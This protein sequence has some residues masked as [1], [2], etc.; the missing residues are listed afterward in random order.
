M[1]LYRATVTI[2][3]YI[4]AKSERDA[5][6]DA[7]E[8]AREQIGLGGIDLDV[9][10]VARGDRIAPKWIGWIPYGT[11]QHAPGP[12]KLGKRSEED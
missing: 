2:D 11:D 7:R 10:P 9:S 12:H 3:M 8:Y 4:R 6:L 1:P 5:E